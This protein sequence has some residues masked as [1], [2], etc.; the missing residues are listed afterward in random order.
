MDH[1]RTD[2]QNRRTRA[3]L[4]QRGYC[5]EAAHGTGGC[6]A[7]EEKSPESLANTLVKLGLLNF[8]NSLTMNKNHH[9]LL[10]STSNLIVDN[11]MQPHT[12][13]RLKEL[14]LKSWNWLLVQT[15]ELLLR[16]TP[17]QPTFNI[18]IDSLTSS[19]F[20]PLLFCIARP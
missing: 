17:S 12:L 6:D 1:T 14:V 2:C 15:P 8:V 3:D 13:P 7:R 16:C 20:P 18:L 10:L 5:F 9:I 11:I 19:K 4:Q